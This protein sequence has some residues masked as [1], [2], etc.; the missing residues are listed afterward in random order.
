LLFK[1]AALAGSVFIEEFELLVSFLQDAA[2]SAAN[3]NND[4][5]YC[6]CFL[7][8]KNLKIKKEI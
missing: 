2:N 1:F 6:N 8:N 7:I 3:N 5:V 4:T